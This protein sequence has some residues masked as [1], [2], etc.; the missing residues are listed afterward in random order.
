MLDTD[1]PPLKK[2]KASHEDIAESVEENCEAVKTNGVT[3]SPVAK[4][5]K[6]KKKSLEVTA[7]R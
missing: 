7:V 6:R 3:S 2:L 1:A 5:K 4:K